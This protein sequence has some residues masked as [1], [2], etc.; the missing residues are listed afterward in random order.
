MMRRVI[1]LSLLSIWF[2]S[3]VGVLAASQCM[4]APC[5]RTQDKSASVVSLSVESMK[6][7][8]EPC[9]LMKA[10]TS[11]KRPE[12]L[13]SRLHIES[14]IQKDLLL[15]TFL[16]FPREKD[17]YLSLRVPFLS[18]PILHLYIRDHRFLI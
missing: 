11:T 2:L 14:F 10:A 8:F 18:P 6:C 1:S 5:C 13:M 15:K 9:A 17:Q 16:N 3:A 4:D 12:G 7:G